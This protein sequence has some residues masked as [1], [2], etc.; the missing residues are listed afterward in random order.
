MICS[1]CNKEIDGVYIIHMSESYAS[2]SKFGTILDILDSKPVG[3]VISMKCPL[4][5]GDVVNKVED[6]DGFFG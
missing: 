5:N 1:S 4:C 2:L 6:D 3:G